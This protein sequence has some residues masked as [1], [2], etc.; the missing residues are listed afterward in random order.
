MAS[1]SKR[2]KLERESLYNI[3]YEYLRKNFYK[4]SEQNKIKVAISIIQILNKD[5]SKSPIGP[6]RPIQIV[7]VDKKREDRL[8]E[9]KKEGEIDCRFVNSQASLSQY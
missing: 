7:F 2:A 9:L 4:F 6:P 3:G 1:L 8:I 5:D